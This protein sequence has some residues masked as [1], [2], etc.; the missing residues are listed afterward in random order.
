M[1]APD[2]RALVESYAR[3]HD[4]Q[5]LASDA[6]LWHA[7][8]PEPVRGREA[9]GAAL[10]LLFY[11]AFA[12]AEADV[13]TV[14]LDGDQRLGFI[15]WT[16]RGRHTGEFLGIPPTGRRVE[17]PMLGIYQLADGFIS[18][19][20]EYYDLATLLRQMGRLG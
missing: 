17:L 8:L 11:E 7:A 2:A 13:Q 4:P 5:Y 14:A 6:T 18:G 16:F 19:G 20:R 12:D 15:E 9:I 10:R 1:S 3:T